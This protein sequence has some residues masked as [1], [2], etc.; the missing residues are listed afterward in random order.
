M[1]NIII[2]LF[3]SVFVGAMCAGLAWHYKRQKVKAEIGV[4]PNEFK[5]SVFDKLVTWVKD[6]FMY[7]FVN[8][9]VEKMYTVDNTLSGPV[10]K[11]VMTNAGQEEWG[12]T[13]WSM[14]MA[15]GAG[16]KKDEDFGIGT[17]GDLNGKFWVLKSKLAQFRQAVESNHNYIMSVKGIELT[18]EHIYR[19]LKTLLEN[20]YGIDIENPYFKEL[21]DK[22]NEKM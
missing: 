7:N 3:V 6:L 10:I 1:R 18:N 21:F 22:Y 17:A 14:S 5:A 11:P 13:E 20:N 16:M 2:V 8:S 15:Q 12:Q 4:Y 19:H 9:L